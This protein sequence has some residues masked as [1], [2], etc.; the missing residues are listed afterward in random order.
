V[1]TDFRAFIADFKGGN[2]ALLDEIMPTVYAELRKLAQSYMRQER[3]ENTLQ[4]TALVHEA[5]LRMAGQR[6]VDWRNRA[7]L[8]AIAARMMRRILMDHAALHQAAKRAGGAVRVTLEDSLLPDPGAGV[9]FLEVD[10]ALER[11]SEI[12]PQQASVVELRF[13]GGLKNEEIAEVLRM[14]PT[15]VRRRWSSARLWL[16]RHLKEEA[17][18]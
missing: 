9:D 1:G 17:A 4:P 7:Q 13:F 2:R 14:S 16:A 12:D 8:L 3:P 18:P 11:L 6:T 10:R 15:S 5:Y